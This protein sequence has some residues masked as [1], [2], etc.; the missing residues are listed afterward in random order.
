MLICGSKFAYYLQ[1]VALAAG[2]KT[3]CAQMLL[4]HP[5]D[6]RFGHATP[7]IGGTQTLH[8]LHHKP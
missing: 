7:S 5:G 4:C 2:G 3:L 1:S 6:L 8:G